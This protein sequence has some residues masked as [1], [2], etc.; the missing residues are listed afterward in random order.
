METNGSTSEEKEE[1][2]DLDAPKII[3]LVED[4]ETELSDLRTQMESDF[5]LLTL[6]GFSAEKG[7]ESYTSSQPRN[8]FDK[9]TDAL[10]RAALSIQIKLPEDAKEEDR[11]AAST[12]ELFLFGGLN[13]I[14]RNL[15]RHGEPPLRHSLAFFEDLRGWIVLRALVYV[16]G[17]RTVFDVLPWDILHTTWEM[18]ADGLLWGNNKRKLTKAQI[19]A[20]Y[21]KDIKGK[22]A[23]LYDFWHSEPGEK[24]NK[25]T[26]SIIVG[27][28]FVKEP[29]E[30]KNLNHIPIFIGSVGSMPTIQ[31]KSFQSTI[32]HRGDSVWS[33]SRDLYK[34][35]NKITSR[36]MDLYERAVIGSIIH[37]SK[38]G[39][40]EV[41]GDPYKTYQ[42]VKISSDDDEEITT[43]PLPE[44]PTET[45]ILSSIINTDI[46]TSTLPYP[47]AYGGTRQA[48]SGAALSVLADATRSVYSPR[49]GVMA[50]AYTWLC[51]ELLSQFKENGNKTT[52][53]GY[54]QKEHF[55]TVKVKPKQIDPSWYVNVSVE[56][57]MPRDMESEIMMS[58]AATQRKSPEDIPL[59][60][61]QT[62]REDILKLRDPDA[63][64]DKALA[65][66][67]MG[68]PPI[69][70]T[71]IAVALKK[72][73]KED[74]AQ[75]VI[76]LLNPQAMQRPQLPPEL[77]AAAVEA[78]A[79][80]PDTQELARAI[81]QV[82]SQRGTPTGT[83]PTGTPPAGTPP[84]ETPPRKI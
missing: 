7:Y 36:T 71:Q 27:E 33:A 10:N 49:C 29:T 69:M 84:A 61:K 37:K 11:R 16:L 34:P 65:E 43:F 74:L 30:L 22:D 73:G 2:M 46:Q 24:K 82:M 39:D 51:E 59:I 76:A 18:G 15:R 31:T 48:M 12:G 17:D 35:F 9:V 40:K 6:E 4:K 23:T 54:N 50:Q 45:A 1:V 83:P 20:I 80:N 21:K 72:Q 57:R 64:S 52:L 14:D 53:S 55:F 81:A 13:D 26:N 56:P 75:D 63:E 60:S 42:E 47:L 41:P 5:G 3:A 62:A 66:I 8:F 58:L 78:L 38:H 77:I 44:L 70:A 79:A 28:E 67:G 68:L 25:I 32:K 19:L